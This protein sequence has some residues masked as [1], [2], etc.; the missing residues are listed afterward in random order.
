MR[1]KARGRMLAPTISVSERVAALTIKAALLFTWMLSH[2]DDQ[3]RLSGDPNTV[4]ALI[5]PLRRDISVE[6]VERALS[7]LEDVGLIKLYSALEAGGWSPSDKVVQIS[8]WWSYQALRDPAPSRYP[9][10]AGW[11]DKVGGQGRDSSG[12]YSAR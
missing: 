12:R 7:D 9:P 3:G 4:K 10:P 5:V 8:D 1:G 6:D 2:A 11:R